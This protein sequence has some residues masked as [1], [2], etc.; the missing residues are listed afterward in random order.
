[1]PNQA[2]G[3]DFTVSLTATAVEEACTP[4]PD[5]SC[6]A[7]AHASLVVDERLRGKEKLTARLSGF[8][9]DTTQADFG[10]P[11]DGNTR[12]DVCIY[13]AANQ[14]RASLEVPRAGQLCGP[15]QK[16]CWKAK[17]DR[18]WTY[19]DPAGSADGV[20]LLQ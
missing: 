17:Q 14:L 18:G 9:E 20:N 4:V 16:P 15:D 10:N 12:Y 3:K 1:T 7:A 2:D 5:T 11:V 19:K 6:L 8:A 13:D